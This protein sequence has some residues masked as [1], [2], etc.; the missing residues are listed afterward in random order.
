M[1]RAR[2]DETEQAAVTEALRSRLGIGESC[3]FL[4]VWDEGDPGRGTIEIDLDPPTFGR[5][6][7][8]HA[9]KQCSHAI[10][11]VACLANGKPSVRGAAGQMEVLDRPLGLTC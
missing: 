5:L 7:L 11:Q 1:C 8:G 10:E 4:V 9:G 6:V 2:E 3:E